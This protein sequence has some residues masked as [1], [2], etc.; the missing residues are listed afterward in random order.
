MSGLDEYYN[1][2]HAITESIVNDMAS[3]SQFFDTSAPDWQDRQSSFSAG[4]SSGIE[5]T[6]GMFYG[7]KGL[8]ADALGNED[9]KLEAI[10]DMME[11]S[12]RASVYG[13]GKVTDL[14]DINSVSDAGDY[15]MYGAG[16]VLPD[17]ALALISGGVG[18]SVGKAFAGKR[19]AT[20]LGRESLEKYAQGLIGRSLLVEG[21]EVVF[22]KAALNAMKMGIGNKAKREELGGVWNAIEKDFKGDMAKK[23]AGRANI[24]QSMVMS[25]GEAYQGTVEGGNA[26]WKKGAIFGSFAGLVEGYGENRILKGLF[27]EIAKT[28]AT[29]GALRKFLGTLGKSMATEGGTEAVQETIFEFNKALADDGWDVE[30]AFG[31]MA[32]MTVLKRLA[33]AFAMG[34]IGGGMMGGGTATMGAIYDSQSNQKKNAE[35][36]AIEEA[37]TADM[38][39]MEQE[40]Q[41]M[42]GETIQDDGLTQQGVELTVAEDQ[43]DGEQVIDE[44]GLAQDTPTEEGLI[45]DDGLT[46]EIDAAN[47]PTKK[48]VPVRID[49]KPIAPTAPPKEPRKPTIVTEETV[50]NV[51]SGAYRTKKAKLMML[52]ENQLKPKQG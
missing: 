8:V 37:Q 36:D 16:Q 33:N 47:P 44:D 5:G 21:K 4:M 48:E 11:H 22:D 1:N 25:Q 42:V 27:P 50:A 17:L 2:E 45:Q 12:R 51:S 52:I 14:T 41:T 38:Q 31:E 20:E 3:T 46:Q 6:K 19:I 32:N 18:A 39:A 29:K 24:A 34:S 28:G 40:V 26:D 35:E 43:V 7:F 15:V 13:T 30:K 10:D 23:W 49:D 9:A